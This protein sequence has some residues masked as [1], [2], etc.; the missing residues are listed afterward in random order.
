[1]NIDLSFSRAA[2]VLPK[3]HS[4]LKIVIIGAGGTGSFAAQAIARLVFELER[5]RLAYMAVSCIDG[6]DW[7][8]CGNETIFK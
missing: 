6:A 5:I 3:E 7:V 2:F 1:M 8:R 4:H